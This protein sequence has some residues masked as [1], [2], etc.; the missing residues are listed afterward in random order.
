MLVSNEF[1]DIICMDLK[2]L[3]TGQKILHMVDLFTKFSAT[4][5]VK[6]KNPD[7]IIE[8]MF[9]I[10]IVIFGRPRKVFSDNGLESL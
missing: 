7:R 5:I 10:W 6:D 8:A 1:N 4:A 3:E 9:K 2:K